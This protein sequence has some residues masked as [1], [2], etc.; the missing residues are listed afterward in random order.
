MRHIAGQEMGKK[1]LHLELAAGSKYEKDHVL[2]IG[3]APGD[4]RAAHKNGALFYP[5]NPGREDTS[6]QRFY[7]EAFDRWLEPGDYASRPPGELHGPFIADEECIVL[8]MSYP[9][10]SSTQ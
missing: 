1:A 10:Q 9:S 8:E 5:I 7:D 2:M 3:D 4:M 6:W